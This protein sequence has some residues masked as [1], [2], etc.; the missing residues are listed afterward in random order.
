MQVTWGRA[1]VVGVKIGL[2]GVPSPASERSCFHRQGRGDGCVKCD[3][4]CL[5]ESWPILNPRAID[6]VRALYRDDGARYG[7]T[8][9]L[10]F[11]VKPSVLGDPGLRRFFAIASIPS[12]LLQLS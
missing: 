10:Y 12:F 1:V 7:D 5:S 4:R 11:I 2:Y 9:A 8:Y 6:T 3:A